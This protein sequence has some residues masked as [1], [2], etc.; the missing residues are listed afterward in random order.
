MLARR[1]GCNRST[2]VVLLSVG[3]LAT[4]EAQTPPARV[5]MG[6]GATIVQT[7]SAVGGD[8]ESVHRVRLASEE[9]LHYEWFLEEVHGTGDT[10]RQD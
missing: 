4:A 8:R 2:W 10:V 1:H 6:T 3:A 9:G 5:P 7:L